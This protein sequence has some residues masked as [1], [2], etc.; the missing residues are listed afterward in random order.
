M[1]YNCQRPPAA[2]RKALDAARKAAGGRRLLYDA[3]EAPL[4]DEKVGEQ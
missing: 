2:V 3:M 4:S 1:R